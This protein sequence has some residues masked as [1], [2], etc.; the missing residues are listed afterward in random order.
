M[1]INVSVA[2]VFLYAISITFYLAKFTDL[3]PIYLCYLALL[4]PSIYACIKSKLLNFSFDIQFVLV[5]LLY[6]FFFHFKSIVTGEFLNLFLGLMGYIFIRMISYRISYAQLIF[7]FKCML[8]VSIILLVLDSLYRVTHPTL[9]NEEMIDT[10]MDSSKWFYLYKFN[11]FMFSDSNTTALIAVILLFGIFSL[12]NFGIKKF[13]LEILF[14]ILILLSCF[15][16]SAVISAVITYCFYAFKTPLR[17][18]LLICST[19]AV[20]ILFMINIILN[21][22]EDG[23]FQSKF[24]ILELI[25]A[26][27]NELSLY[28]V[29]FGLGIGNS[30]E[31][32]GLFPH[33]FLLT[34]FLE[35]G[36]TG[37]FLILSFLYQY[38]KKINY[39]I[40]LSAMIMGLSYFLY[41][42]TPF[43]FVP[44]SLVCAIQMNLKTS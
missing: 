31:F 29:L 37:T 12:H 39:L 16:R 19:S 5:I 8:R 35:T 32:L 33:V 15:S 17:R 40:P 4:I 25:A 7:I 26:K 34:W 10:M 28:D 9:P 6:I 43:L 24:L 21:Y 2:L 30:E 18:V 41:L 22:F 1:K 11:S 3:S 36:I 42:G 13:Q 27:F 44:M 38:A 20:V 23:S 14:L